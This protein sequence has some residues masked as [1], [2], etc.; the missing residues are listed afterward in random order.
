[1]TDA[2]PEQ[3]ER[4][5]SETA[6]LKVPSFRSS[7][8]ALAW[9]TLIVASIPWDVQNSG[10]AGLNSGADLVK[11]AA[12]LAASAVAVW[13]RDRSER[14]RGLTLLLL[15]YGV[16]VATTSTLIDAEAGAAM[17][18]AVRLLV[19]VVAVACLCTTLGGR[20]QL[21][22]FAGTASTMA[23]VALIARLLGLGAE[24][25]GRL[26]GLLPPMHPNQLG[27]IAAIAF[28]IIL[29]RVAE[30]PSIRYYAVLL[31]LLVC[32][33]ASGS[34]TAIIAVMVSS[35]FT[36]LTAGLRRLGFVCLWLV[37]TVLTFLAL[38]G[39]LGVVRGVM[40]RNGQA[41][42]DL[43]FTGRTNAWSAAASMERSVGEVAIGSGLTAKSVEVYGFAWDSQVLDST[44]F[45]AYVEAG[46]VGCTLLVACAVYIIRR[47]F[48]AR[49]LM[50][51]M[52]ATGLLILIETGFVS[53]LDDVTPELLVWVVLTVVL[54]HP[55]H[56]R[57][58]RRGPA[59]RSPVLAAEG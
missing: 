55:L 59:A 9:L 46:V 13:F 26:A 5:H 4:Q 11:S 40:D 21:S 20:R 17:L 48:A 32:I 18:R 37:A 45:S 6:L 10:G 15:G 7:L 52:L 57:R 2:R 27:S 41:V 12:V 53:A 38:F 33:A 43:S 50:P 51:E 39:S 8:A 31:L 47:G 36:L 54:G 58:A 23:I 49:R 44:W 56:V 34:R 42:F 29:M 25:E 30:R 14:M 19:T 1:M 24:R 28:V 22:L 35:I 16:T 3:V